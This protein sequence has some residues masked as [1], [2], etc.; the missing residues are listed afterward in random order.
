[1]INI[2]LTNKKIYL[3]ENTGIKSMLNESKR[4][5]TLII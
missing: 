5:F 1:M 2:K 3:Q 4:W